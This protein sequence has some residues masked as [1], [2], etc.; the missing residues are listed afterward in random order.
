MSRKNVERYLS[1]WDDWGGDGKHNDEEW[2]H[3]Q[4]LVTAGY[5]CKGSK[6]YTIANYSENKNLNAL[7]QTIHCVFLF[8]FQFET[9]LPILSIQ[10]DWLFWHLKLGNSKIFLKF[11]QRQRKQ[12]FCSS[13]DQCSLKMQTFSLN[14][15]GPSIPEWQALRIRR[16]SL[17]PRVPPCSVVKISWMLLPG[18]CCF[19]HFSASMNPFLIRCWRESSYNQTPKQL[20]LAFL[21]YL[22]Y[23]SVFIC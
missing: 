1:E 4:R 13:I 2:F 7:K 20:S 23:C 5:Y 12:W 8:P 3:F 16:L 9:P 15:L 22:L 17:S 11:R 10:F 14:Q 21:K 19:G 18:N 6:Y